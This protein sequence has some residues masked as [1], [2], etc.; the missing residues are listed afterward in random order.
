LESLGSDLPIVTLEGPL[1]RGRH[2]AAILR[3]M[4][5][6]ETI[7]RNVDDYVGIAARLAGDLDERRRVKSAI[8]AT[9]HRVYRDR[10]CIDALKT[11]LERV[12]RQRAVTQ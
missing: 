12:G 3:M 2:S 4:G 9:K 7:A 10:A 1:M 6:A 8:A 5:V 11:F